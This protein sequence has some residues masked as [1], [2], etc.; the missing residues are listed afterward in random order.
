MNI[1]IIILTMSKDK[2]F[3][4]KNDDVVIHLVLQ[5]E[6]AFHSYYFASW[7]RGNAVLF[8]I[9]TVN[10]TSFGGDELPDFSLP[11]ITNITVSYSILR[12]TN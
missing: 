7:L 6:A 4:L 9:L 12:F 8:R 5:N 1:V 10:R 3:G 11:H 2:R